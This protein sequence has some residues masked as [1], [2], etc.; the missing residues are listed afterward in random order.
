M[1]EGS[2]WLERH[3]PLRPP[4]SDGEELASALTHGVG[5]LASVLGLVLLIVRAAH[6][7]SASTVV[8]V[9]IFGTSMI[10][11]YSA[12]CLYHSFREPNKKRICRIV[13]HSSIYLLIAGTYTPMTLAM[14]GVWGWTV[15]GIVWA[16]AFVGI[17]L[18]LFRMKKSKIVTA[19]V[20]LAMGW[21]IIIAWGPFKKVVT[22]E[23][24]N[25]AIAGGLT[26]TVGTVFYA[27]KKMPYHH[28]VWHLF[29]L[30][31]SAFLWI[32]IFF[33]LI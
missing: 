29:V 16:F 14:G 27:M 7:D 1:P 19:A 25:W 8:G 2:S 4:D 9:T 21:T 30:G 3:V 18:E 23:F 17:C 13:D 11:L 5:A 31:G 20:Y 24:F 6:G 28:A 10:L 22:P 32:G 26:Y 12:S 15:F 33:H